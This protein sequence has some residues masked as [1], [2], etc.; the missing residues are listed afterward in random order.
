MPPNHPVPRQN[1][2][3]K[4]SPAN[5][6]APAPKLTDTRAVDAPEQTKIKPRPFLQRLID[7]AND[8]ALTDFEFR[9]LVT[10][11]ADARGEDGVAFGAVARYAK[12]CGDRTRRGIQKARAR[13]KTLNLL[14]EP[15][16]HKTGSTE[17]RRFRI[18]PVGW[19]REE[20][21]EK[22]KAEAA[23]R[24]AETAREAVQLTFNGR[25]ALSAVPAPTEPEDADPAPE[26]I[27]PMLPNLDTERVKGGEPPFAP[28]A[29]E[30]SPPREPFAPPANEGS[31]PREPPF[32][33]PRMRVRP[34]VYRKGYRKKL[35]LIFTARAKLTAS[36]SSSKPSNI[37]S[38]DCSARSPV[39]LASYART[40]MKPTSGTDWPAARSGLT[41]CNASR[42]SWLTNWRPVE[43][44]D[45][46]PGNIFSPASDFRF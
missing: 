6:E 4:R 12:R 5:Q 18:T 9:L 13:L 20:D 17:T 30:G 15:N 7:A 45:C 25:A 41:T 36:N 39:E 8:Q 22:R 40:M 37:A 43:R 10:M 11:A 2:T 34:K 19:S 16:D 46:K 35:L 21:V 31:P 42:T 23:Q 44:P 38:K 3:A 24:N 26:N 29:N 32:A 33:P 14:D 1:T 27:V 28:P